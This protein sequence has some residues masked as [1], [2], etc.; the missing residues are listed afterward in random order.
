MRQ[1]KR[2]AE[3]LESYDTLSSAVMAAAN[4]LPRHPS[5]LAHAHVQALLS[6]GQEMLAHYAAAKHEAGLVNYSDMIVMA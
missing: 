5:L 6:T 1:S 2:G 3:L 4:E